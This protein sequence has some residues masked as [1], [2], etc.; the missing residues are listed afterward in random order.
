[1]SYVPDPKVVAIVATVLEH[2]HDI[3]S[4]YDHLP[5]PGPAHFDLAACCAMVQEESGGR[6]IWGADPWD[7]AAYPRGRALPIALCEQP[8]TAGAYQAYKRKRDQGLQ[9]QGCG[10]TQLTSPSL[11]IMAEQAG[12]CW[13]PFYN[14]KIGFQ[15]LRGLFATHTTDVAAFA[16]YNG[17]GPAADAYGERVATLQAQWQAR[18]S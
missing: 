2:A 16:A 1:M 3:V 5:Q 8:V 11:Q 14:A 7:S 10:I 4:A 18:L 6:M 9:P 15:V 13:V 12:G 17:S